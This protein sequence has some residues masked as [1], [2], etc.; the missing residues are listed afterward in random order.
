MTKKT[1]KLIF[2]LMSTFFLMEHHHVFSMEERGEEFSSNPCK[3]KADYRE[4]NDGEARDKRVCLTPEG[5]SQ[6]SSIDLLKAQVK[7]KLISSSH[8]FEHGDE[9]QKM[10]GFSGLMEL[11]KKN[12]LPDNIYAHNIRK[13]VARLIFKEG[14]LGQKVCVF[15]EGGQNLYKALDAI[16]MTSVFAEQ[17][18]ICNDLITIVQSSLLS[19]IDH[20]MKAKKLIFSFGT[21]DQKEFGFSELMALAN[22]HESSNTRGNSAYIIFNFGT[23]DQKV[24]ALSIIGQNLYQP[25][26]SVLKTAPVDKEKICLELALILKNDQLS[27]TCQMRAG[28]LILAVGTKKQKTE[29]FSDLMA[30][31][32]NEDLPDDIRRDAAGFIFSEGNL[33]QKAEA[34]SV[35]GQNLYAALYGLTMFPTDKEK[36]SFFLREILQSSKISG[37]DR[38]RAE[39]LL[40]E[41]KSEAKGV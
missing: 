13:D 27:L 18:K 10:E 16:L 12:D 41:F 28:S 29:A 5:T 3:R 17:E 19:E 39:T 38:T 7:S 37:I 33:E 31:A 23:L 40:S 11:A 1:K 30:F 4:G 24:R 15:S 26:L 21:P 35:G 36:V 8:L 14:D 22:T 2:I 34:F 20:R 9:K 6:L 32:T 25:L